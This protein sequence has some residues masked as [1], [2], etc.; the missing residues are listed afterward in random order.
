MNDFTLNICQ[1]VIASLKTICQLFMVETQLMHNGGLQI[2]NVDSVLRDLESQL[3][4]PAVVESSFDSS[5]GHPHR[6][7]IRIVVSAKDL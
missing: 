6:E 2:V 7:T 1:S 5:T 4:G 3:I